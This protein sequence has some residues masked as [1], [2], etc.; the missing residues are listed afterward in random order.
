[1]LIDEKDK[2][3]GNYRINQKKAEACISRNHGQLCI[4]MPALGEVY[5]KQYEKGKKQ[6]SDS[7]DNLNQLI[8]RS[9]FKVKFIDRAGDAFGIAREIIRRSMSHKDDRSVISP[10]DALIISTA[11][12]DPDSSV[13]YTDDQ[14]LIMNADVREIIGEYREG[15]GNKLE[16]KNIRNLLR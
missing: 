9:V 10:M 13:F 14:E 1:M 12:A 8:D 6:Y 7:F 5:F 3:R 11:I 16:L 15:F 2:L 4:P